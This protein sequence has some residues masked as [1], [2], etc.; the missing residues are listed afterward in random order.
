MK[1]LAY[2][3]V[4]IACFVGMVCFSLFSSGLSFFVATVSQDLGVGRGSFTLYYSL[5]AIGGALAAPTMGKLAGKYG[6][7]KLM[8]ISAVWGCSA[9]LLFSVAS[10]LWMFYV[11]GLAAGLMGNACVM[12]CINVALQRSYDAKTMSAIMGVVMAGS[13]VGGMLLSAVMPGLLEQVGWRAGYRLLGIA[14]LALVLLSVVIMGKEQTSAAA[15]DGA[16]AGGEAGMTQAQLLKT[17][18]M[19]LLILESLILA[20]SCGILQQYP[21]LLGGMGFDTATVAT[22]MSLMTAS[23]AVGKIAQ[24]ALY[25]GVGVRKGGA[26]AILIFAAG[27]LLLLRAGTVYPALVLSAIGLGVYTTLMP[28]VTRKVFG[29]SFA[30][31]WGMV[32]LGGSL[33]GFIGN[34]A[35]GAVYDAT[36]SYTLALVVFPVILAATM[37]LHLVLTRDKKAG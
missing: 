21:A 34:P 1:K 6:V 14:W 18:A 33:G 5:M 27:L 35:W 30:A 13:G 29:H 2:Y 12:L 20:A 7:R 23:I 11:V 37:V 36:G 19:Y 28:L 25:S 17:P 4:A 8:I 10:A 16:A 26:V 24:G 15:A 9:M 32:Q 31:A 22:M 3:R